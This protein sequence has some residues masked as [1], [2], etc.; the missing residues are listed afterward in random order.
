M[1]K[2]KYC[3]MFTIMFCVVLMSGC[4][5]PLYKPFKRMTETVVPEYEKYIDADKNLTKEQKQ[6]RKGACEDAR[7]L[8]R[9]YR[10]AEGD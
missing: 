4:A 8:L 7:K 2:I 1:K 6:R 9:D 5:N 3:K 10:E